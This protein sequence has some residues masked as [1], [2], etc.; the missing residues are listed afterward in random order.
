MGAA[1]H[2]RG[3]QPMMRCEGASLQRN[4]SSSVADAPELAEGGARMAA[5]RFDDSILSAERDLEA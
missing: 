2:E 3:R 1:R 4:D 5:P